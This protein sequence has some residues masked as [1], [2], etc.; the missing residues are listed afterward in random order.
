MTSPPTQPVTDDQLDQWEKECTTEIE[1]AKFGAQCR[2]I[3]PALTKEVRRLREFTEWQEPHMAREQPCGCVICICN[4]QVK[5]HG[6][7]AK[8]CGSHSDGIIPS[9]VYEHHPL[10]TQLVTMSEALA[11]VV[12]RAEEHNRPDYGAYL[13]DDDI[14]A[15]RSAL[16]STD[17]AAKVVVDRE[18]I[19]F[20]HRVLGLVVEAY[21]QLELMTGVP[22]SIARLDSLRQQ[23]GKG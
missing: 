20:V 14:E 10:L 9:P 4:D 8:N 7:G 1:Q 23:G 19:D 12:E 13:D 3:V 2:T 18:L 16:S 15:A 22:E 5:C 21:P 6:C 17:Y 11:T